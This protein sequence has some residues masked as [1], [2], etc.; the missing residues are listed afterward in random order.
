MIKHFIHYYKPYR[1]LLILDIISAILIAALDLVIPRFSNFLISDIIPLKEFSTLFYWAILIALFFVLR[2]ILNYIVEYYGHVLGVNMEY[3]MR[4]EMFGHIQSLPVSYFDNIKVGKLMS[5]LVNDLNEISELAHHGPEN[6]LIAI[7][8]LVGSFFLMYTSN[9]NL[10]LVMTFLVPLMIIVGVR[11]NLKFRSA[12]RSMRERLAE[13]NAQAQDNFSGIR[14]VKAYNAEEQEEAQF[15]LG[16]DFFAISRKGALKIMAQ[17]GVTVKGFILLITLVVF[18]Y[19]GYLVMNDQMTIGQLV[20]FI[21]YVGVFQQ[22]I[23]RFSELIMMYN[24]A[25]AGFERFLEVMSIEAQNDKEGAHELRNVIGDI[26]FDDVSF[27]YGDRQGKHVLSHISFSV[28]AGSKVAFVGPSGSGKSTLCNLIPRFYELQEGRIT[29]DGQDIRDL[30]IKSLRDQVGIVQQDVFIF[31]G[32]VG[33]NIAYGKIN[34][35]QEEIIKAA[36]RAEAWEFISDLPEGLNTTIGE[37]G[38]KLSGGQR[39][40]LSLARMFLKNPKILLLDEATSALDNKTEHQIQITLDELA[41][42]RTTLVVAHRLSTIKDADW[43]YVLTD[44][45]IH[46]EGTHDQLLDKKGLYYRLV[47]SEKDSAS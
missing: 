11:Q 20:E 17:F 35:T 46:E 47:H 42:D 10:A 30:T 22:P 32:T 29:L 12:F 26:A 4:K 5:R 18:V 45:G 8:L 6:L 43:I 13:I 25:M 21:L 2:L 16:N 14:V 36:Q 38:V 33:Q 28:K 37:R 24:Q 3:D 23:N 34:A 7:V 19:G 1:G 15:A 44:Q 9:V 27:E 40:R 31:A 41:K 39:Q